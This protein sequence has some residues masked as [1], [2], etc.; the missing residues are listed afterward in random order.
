MSEAALRASLEELIKGLS[1]DLHGYASVGGLFGGKWEDWPCA[2]SVGVALPK[3]AMKGVAEGPTADYYKAYHLANA[4]LNRE[5]KAVESWLWDRGYAAEAFPA[6]VTLEELNTNLG[7]GLTAPVQHK[8]VATR[9]GLG[10]IGKSGLLVTR[11]YGPRVRLATVFTDA[12]LPLG[13]PIEDC[14][15]G[16]CMRCVESCP[17]RA[18][19]GASWRAG[20]P[21]D[22]LVD[23]RA[24]ERM[25]E[26]LMLER[27]GQQ[28]AV[29]GV[30]IAVCPFAGILP[31]NA[32]RK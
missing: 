22:E 5:V 10:W 16:S 32:A 12:P 30:C 8:T 26:R 21:R 11:R 4:C 28:D 27:V 1:L 13:R 6:T 3:A 31:G 9:A 24:C 18:I 19:R 14:R 15:C 25:A 29:C 17:A 2:I 23:A 20:M 7:E